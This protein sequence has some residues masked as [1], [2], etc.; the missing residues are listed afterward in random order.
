MYDYAALRQLVNKHDE[1]LTRGMEESKKDDDIVQFDTPALV[2]TKNSDDKARH[3]QS[4]V[5]KHSVTFPAILEFV[6]KNRN[7]IGEECAALKPVEDRKKKPEDFPKLKIEKRLEKMIS[8]FDIAVWEFDD[9][10]ESSELVFS[11]ILNK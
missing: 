8:R 5:M 3:L 10:F 2:V 9:E 6:Q 4:T 11:I 7:L 1:T